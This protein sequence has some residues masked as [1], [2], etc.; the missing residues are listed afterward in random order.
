MSYVVSP[1]HT[2]WLNTS[3]GG[4]SAAESDM[5]TKGRLTHTWVAAHTFGVRYRSCSDTRYGDWLRYRFGKSKVGRHPMYGDD[6]YL[7]VLT[8]WY[9]TSRRRTCLTVPYGYPPKRSSRRR[10]DWYS[11]WVFTK[12]IIP[13]SNVICRTVWEGI[14][15]FSMNVVVP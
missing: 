11:S 4:M 13:P 1:I 9:S 3:D 12:T 5:N 6:N 7:T 14:H 8:I 10:T 15:N 2:V